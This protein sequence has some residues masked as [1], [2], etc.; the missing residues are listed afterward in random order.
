MWKPKNVWSM[1]YQHPHAAL[2][3]G[4]WFRDDRDRQTPGVNGMKCPKKQKTKCNK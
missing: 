3:L 1:L 2:C 4:P